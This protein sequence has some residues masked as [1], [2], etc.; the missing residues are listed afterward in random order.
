MR[1]PDIGH[2]LN[3]P[4][5]VTVTALRPDHR[6]TLHSSSAFLIFHLF[7]R[8]RKIPLT[9]AVLP[10]LNLPNATAFGSL[11]SGIHRNLSITASNNLQE[12]IQGI[13]AV[14]GAAVRADR[15]DILPSLALSVRTLAYLN[16]RSGTVDVLPEYFNIPFDSVW[17]R[18]RSVITYRML[19]FE[20][21]AE[22]LFTSALQV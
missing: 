10:I 11:I 21:L 8:G 6:D 22:L 1:S 15:R 3:M 16:D 13:L 19:R 4:P 18:S 9:Y 5:P 14:G 12:L 7:W 20:Q 17:N 2:N